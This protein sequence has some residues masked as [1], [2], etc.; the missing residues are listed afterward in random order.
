MTRLLGMVLTCGVLAAA[1]TTVTIV[2]R[3]T[4]HPWVAA[5]QASIPVLLPLTSVAAVV[6]AL[7]NRPLTSVTATL[8]VLTWVV[9]SG[10]VGEVRT[11][12]PGTAVLRVL[13]TNLLITNP[14]DGE[15]I[16]D[17]LSQDADV[18]VTLETTD[19]MRARLTAALTGYRPVAVGEGP[20]GSLAVIWQHERLT[21]RLLAV[22]TVAVAGSR[23]PRVE[24]RMPGTDQD[25]R[26]EATVSIVGVHLHAPLDRESLRIWR[27]E[28]AALAALGG[29][30]SSTTILAGDFN[31]GLV[32]PGMHALNSTFRDAAM[33]S[34]KLS[35]RTWPS[36]GHGPLPAV[37]DLDH[38]LVGEGLVVAGHRTVGV[39][40]SDHLGLLV[41]IGRLAPVDAGVDRASVA[42]VE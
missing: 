29:T 14:L 7:V 35:P 19:E 10:G 34:G 39:A 40:G 20:R 41:E 24:Y 2:L 6:A 18:V 3:L 38:V 31:A 8:C 12:P 21:D 4:P 5:A 11:A 26:G 22:G 37:F 36:S 27:R 33:L 17:I 28:L 13:S 30:G 9:I 16:E 32:H 23:L 1:L 25:L 15:T 42:V